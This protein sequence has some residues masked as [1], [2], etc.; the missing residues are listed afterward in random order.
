MDPDDLSVFLDGSNP[1]LA[2]EVS[3]MEME[4]TATLDLIAARSESHMQM[5]LRLDA[6]NVPEETV[7]NYA[8]MERLIGSALTRQLQMATDEMIRSVDSIMSGC[9]KLIPKLA[10]ELRQRF[11]DH[12]IIGMERVTQQTIAADADAPRG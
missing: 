1:N 11:K 7:L 6:A 10:N 5:Q 12:R 2:G 8:E 9:E 3:R 4:I